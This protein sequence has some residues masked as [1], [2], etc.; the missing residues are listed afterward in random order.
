[1]NLK[2]LLGIILLGFGFFMLFGDP[3]GLVWPTRIGPPA[4]KFMKF[5][6][7]TRPYSGIISLALGLASFMLVKKY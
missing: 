7:D 4:V 1:M 5:C 3:T 2:I 6:A